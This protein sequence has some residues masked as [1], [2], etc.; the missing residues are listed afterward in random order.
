MP[1]QEIEDHTADMGIDA[2][3]DSLEGLYIECMS[4][5]SEL[6][7]PDYDDVGR[8]IVH[9]LVVE[10]E[11]PD[12]VLHELMNE[13]L[14]L[15]DTKHFLGNVW[16]KPQLIDTPDG[17]VFTVKVYGGTFVL[18]QHEPGAHIKAV[19]WHQLTCDKLDDGTWYSLIIFD[20]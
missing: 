4:A 20:I 5:F 3:S 1:W 14:Y 9:E 10:G 18:G 6:T 8:S 17:I 2:W 13:L 12:Y 11:E 15:F 7:S 19:S 16:Q